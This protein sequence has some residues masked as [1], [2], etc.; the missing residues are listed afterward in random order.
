MLLDKFIDL[1]KDKS[2]VGNDL[3]SLFRTMDF[4]IGIEASKGV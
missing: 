1:F 4:G 3:Q 2:F